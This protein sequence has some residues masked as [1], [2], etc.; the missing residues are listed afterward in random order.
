[1]LPHAAQ[2]AAS[3]IIPSA[4]EMDGWAGPPLNADSG[5]DEPVGPPLIAVSISNRHFHRV[6]AN[7]P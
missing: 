5:T 6:R 3:L 7:R 4:F 1:V 2:W